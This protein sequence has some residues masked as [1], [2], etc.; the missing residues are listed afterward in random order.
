[1]KTSQS[2]LQADGVSH[3]E[4]I[5]EVHEYLTRNKATLVFDALVCRKLNGTEVLGGM[6]FIYDNSIVPDARKQIITVGSCVF[7]ETNQLNANK[8]LT[9]LASPSVSTSVHLPQCLTITISS[10]AKA[11]LLPGDPFTVQLPPYLPKNHLYEI[12]SEADHSQLEEWPKNSIIKAD[13]DK[14][15]ITND[16]DSPIL[17]SEAAC[18]ATAKPLSALSRQA[19]S[20]NTN[21]QE[22]QKL[23]DVMKEKTKP[24][25]YL[26]LISVDPHRV[27]TQEERDRVWAVL[28][29]Y[30]T[31]FDGDI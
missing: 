10:P 23:V 18:L 28:K 3:L 14:L 30:H 21:T 15:N 24:E 6:D 26:S 1:M 22:L 19:G 5:G 12:K 4:V 13:G 16:T 17:L 27:H 7:P 25:E 9:V 11:V 2:A 8:A 31:V 29:K 20:V